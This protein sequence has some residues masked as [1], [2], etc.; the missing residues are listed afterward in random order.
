MLKLLELSWQD[1]VVVSW[2][3]VFEEIR[4]L[5]QKQS[6]QLALAHSIQFGCQTGLL[7]RLVK[8]VRNLAVREE[9]GAV[10]V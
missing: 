3:Q 5:L 7:T 8:L 2:V 9:A 6:T 10:L 1:H 4:N